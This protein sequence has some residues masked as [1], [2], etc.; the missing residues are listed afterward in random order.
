[1]SD[2]LPKVYEEI[3]ARFNGYEWEAC[4]DVVDPVKIM[5]RL[6]RTG[7]D[8]KSV[9]IDYRYQPLTFQGICIVEMVPVYPY[10]TT[11]ITWTMNK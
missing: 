5:R 11:R 4:F 1:M 10:V 6:K 3:G 9:V 8:I 7:A 2:K